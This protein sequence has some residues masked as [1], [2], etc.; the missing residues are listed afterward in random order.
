MHPHDGG[1]MIGSPGRAVET[2]LAYYEAWSDEDLER[3][4]T[5]IADDVVCDAPDGRIEGAHAYKGFVEPFFP[6]LR[7]AELTAFGDDET[8][9]LL[10]E[11]EG[12]QA[13]GYF[14]V[15]GGKIT[16]I[17]FTF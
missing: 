17:R 2:A 10:Y 11:T 16:R 1:A 5:F 15:E 12:A 6:A 7:G 14:T 9:V 8:A 3:T 13:A 4:M